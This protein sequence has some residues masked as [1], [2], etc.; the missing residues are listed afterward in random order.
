M[1]ERIYRVVVNQDGAH[2]IWPAGRDLPPGWTDEGTAG[3]KETCLNRIGD[4][5]TD[6]RPIRSRRGPAGGKEE[7]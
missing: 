5:W 6:M 1:T 2:S 7:A 3:D 4:V